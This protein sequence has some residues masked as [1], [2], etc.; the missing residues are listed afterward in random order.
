MPRFYKNVKFARLDLLFCAI[1]LFLNPYGIAK[2]FLKKKGEKNLYQYGETPL[3]TFAQIIKA[4][5]LKSYDVFYE[6]G[7]GRGCNCLWLSTHHQGRIVGIEWIPF[8]VSIA[9]FLKRHFHLN[10]LNIL[11]AN[12][13]DVDISTANCVYIFDPSLS[14]ELV[15]KLNVLKPGSKVITISYPLTHHENA[16]YQLVKI[17]PVSF[18]WGKTYAYVQEKL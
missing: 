11:N 3:L 10:N 6:L 4:A 18:P 8:F 2:K 17:M 13:L 12:M 7:C 9:S 5:E 1:Y 16:K 14:T 15:D